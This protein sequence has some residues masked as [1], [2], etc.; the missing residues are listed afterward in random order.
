MGRAPATVVDDPVWTDDAPFL[1]CERQFD[2]IGHSRGFVLRLVGVPITFELLHPRRERGQFYGQLRVLSDLVGTR[3]FQGAIGAPCTLNL[4]SQRER[5]AHAH[6]L[7][8]LSRAPQIDWWRLLEEFS[9][10]VLAAEAD[11]EPAIFLHDVVPTTGEIHF[12]VDGLEFTR[13][14]ANMIFGE[15]DTLKSWMTLRILGEL[16]SRG[17]PVALLDWELDEE[18]YHTRLT[19]LYG[20]QPPPI[21]YLPCSRA[22]SLEFDRVQREFHK[23]RIA[24]A[25]VDSVV[26]AGGSANPND[27]E[28]ANQIVGALRQLG[29]GSL[30]IAHVPKSAADQK[31]YEKPFGSQFWFNLCRSIWYVA[32]SSNDPVVTGFYHRKSSL[33]RRRPDV[34]LRW[35]FDGDTGPVHVTRATLA[36]VPDLAERQS[37]RDRLQAL[38][39]RGPALSTDAA[40]ELGIKA[41]TLK[42]TVQ[43]NPKLFGK[44]L[45]V[46]GETRLSLVERRYGH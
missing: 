44:Q 26:P 8:E 46:D 13:K 25:G 22:L 19:Q 20:S 37:I 31:G 23:H 10:R 21:L 32:R 40:T 38:L 12:D 11:G 42:K 45:G 28:A 36:D 33:S 2:V 16:A 1:T 24:F 30:L 39:R 35:A 15:S 5:K 3:H 7:K 29:V 6:Q 34:G 17:V 43:R 9:A 27:P 18:V 41:D 14:H 4:S